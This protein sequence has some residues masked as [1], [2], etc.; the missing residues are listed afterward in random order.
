MQRG[1]L[2][3]RRRSGKNTVMTKMLTAK[4]LI[5]TAACAVSLAAC[6]SRQPPPVVVPEASSAKQIVR[7][8]PELVLPDGTRVT[9]DASGGFTLPN[10]AYVQRDARGAL[11]LPTGA[12]C[13]PNSGG[14]ACP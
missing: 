11:V 7:Q 14:Y 12:R 13:L 4:T 1:I 10:G 2:H 6:V 5:A 9:P 8:G 3:P